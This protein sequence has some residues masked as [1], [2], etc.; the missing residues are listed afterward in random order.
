M[1]IIWEGV[2]KNGTQEE[3]DKVSHYIND[4]ITAEQEK[5]RM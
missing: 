5:A 4:L 1:A 2:L 3:R